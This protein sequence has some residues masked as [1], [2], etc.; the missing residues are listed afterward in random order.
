M[1]LEK[2]LVRR[3]FSD[4]P[5]EKLKITWNAR[6]RKSAGQ[7][8]NHSNGNSTVEMSPVVCTTAERVRDTLI[9]ELCHAAVWIV[10]RL[11]KEGHGPGWKR[12]GA[13]CS[14]T[15]RSLPFVER[16][17]SYEI[18]AKFFYVCENNFCAQTL[19]LYFI[20]I[21]RE[22]AKIEVL[23]KIG[24]YKLTANEIHFSA[25]FLRSHRFW[26]ALYHGA[27]FQFQNQASIEISG[28]GT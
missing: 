6:L 9:H 2:I 13:R 12:W 21:I 20:I 11:H 5:S 28:Y 23:A 25:R 26:H 14:S 18:E 22:R 1:K 15:F 10:D 27:P 24:N 8:R 7:C 4:I 17:H 19:V 16:C 3:I